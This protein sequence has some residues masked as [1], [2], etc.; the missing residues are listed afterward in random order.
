MEREAAHPLD[1]ERKGSFSSHRGRS[2]YP[3]PASSSYEEMPPRAS[4]ISW[5]IPLFVVANVIVFIVTMYVNNCPKNSFNCRLTFLK[6]LSFE[7]L[8]DNP[9]LG[10]SS[11]TLKKMGALNS[12]L[13]V[14]KHQGW[15]LIS[16]MWLH[17]GVL[18]LLANMICLLLIGIRLEREFGFVKIGLLYL[19]SGFGGS[20]LS[21]LF[22]QDRISVG[23]SGALF[24]LLGA[25]VSEL[26]TNWSIY[27]NKIAALITLVII[28][29]I[30]LAVGI[31]PHVDNFA[32]IG[33]FVSGFLLGFVLLMRPQLGWVR[34]QGHAGMPG[35]APVKSRHK[36][37]QIVLLIVAVL[38]LVAG[39]STAIALLYKEVDVN[40]KCSWCHYL[41]CVPTSHWNCNGSKTF[42]CEYNFDKGYLTVVCEDRT[43]SREWPSVTSPTSDNVYC[44]RSCR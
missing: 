44:S 32:H 23:A 4:R 14:K 42:E 8:R 40:K 41:S 33:G 26:I 37:Y 16:C 3:V 18:H 12:T 30:N 5:L 36:I 15:R 1:I 2:V 21:A 22:I 7:S 9:L 35:G 17:A 25:M 11:E 31:L 28:I 13:V 38:L 24:G 27:S 20:L 6:R 34:H 39:Y 29:G 10:P 19:L 43:R